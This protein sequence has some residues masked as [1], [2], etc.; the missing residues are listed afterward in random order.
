M[1]R[2]V[3]YSVSHPLVGNLLMVLLLVLGTLAGKTLNRETFPTMALDVVRVQVVW[4]GASPREVELGICVKVEEAVRGIAGI[5]QVQSIAAENGGNITILLQRGTSPEKA[6]RD[7]QGEVDRILS[8]PEAA[9]EP[10]ISLLVQ[11][12]PVLEVVL[13]GDAERSALKEI[14]EELRDRLMKA[15]AVSQVELHGLR[16]QEISVELSE[17]AMQRHG[18]TFAQVSAAIAAANLDLTS[19]TVRGVSE[20]IRVRTFGKRYHARDLTSLVVYADPQGR[21]ILLG[22]IASVIERWEELPDDLLFNGKP[23]VALRVQ[24]S[25][26]EDTLLIVAAAKAFREQERKKLPAGLD[27]ELYA[28]MSKV[29]RDR[30][31][32]LMRNGAIGLALVLLTLTI[33]LNLRL[34][35]WV[36]V[37]LPISFAGTFLVIA[38]FGS[39][40]INVISLFGLIIVAGILV[41]DAIVVSENVYAHVERGSPPHQAAIEGTAEVAPAVI[42]SVTTTMVTFTPLFFTGGMIGKFIWQVAAIVIIALAMSLVEC[43]FV[44]P[45]H[46]A[47]SIARGQA[48]RSRKLPP[49]LRTL[50][51]VGRAVRTRFDAG[52]AWFVRRVYGPA[53]ALAVK[54]RWTS[55][56]TMIGVV[57][58]CISMLQGGQQKFVFFPRIDSDDVSARYVLAPGTPTEAATAFVRDVEDKLAILAAQLKEEDPQNRDVVLRVRTSVGRHSIRQALIAMMEGSEVVEVAA[59]ILP[60]E[61]RT[62]S[63]RDVANRLAELVGPIPGAQQIYYGNRMESTFGKP[64]HVSFLGQDRIHLRAVVDRVKTALAE[65]PGVYG[66]AD[67]A[68]RGR[69]EVHLTLTEKGRGL[70]LTLGEIALQLRQGFYGHEVHRLQRGRNEVKLMVRYPNSDRE[71]LAALEQAR[72][73]TRDGRE[74]PLPEVASWELTDGTVWLK[75]QDFEGVI[76]VFADVDESRTNAAEVIRDMNATVFADVLRDYPDVEMSMEGQSREQRKVFAGVATV[77]P[78]AL[79]IMVVILILVFQSVL[80]ALLIFLMIPL[81]FV[82][83]LLSHHAWGIPITVMSIMGFI[84]LCG[85]VINDSVVF[86]HRINTNVRNG[87]K[88]YAAA[89]QGGQD[90]FRAILLTTLTTTA[91]LG[92]LVFETS[93]QAQF[94]IPMALTLAGGLLVGTLFTLLVLPAAYLCLNDVRRV[95]RWL[96][97]GDWPDRRSVEPVAAPPHE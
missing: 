30:M 18:V 37:G 95:A 40:T 86:V 74:L 3:A 34:S 38:G 55:L 84:A 56:L 87:M 11:K 45:A 26:A 27:I 2:L 32:L 4:P 42:A 62:L 79:F 36:A 6:L 20:E 25:P 81:G 1:R 10:S 59:E 88:P 14:A 33:F 63:S 57:V 91:G 73:R 43:L 23:A 53:V 67:D 65:Y 8:F 78:M 35:F 21:S 92:P 13:F 54:R 12:T 97:T 9:E 31:D 60:G 24:K 76:Q 61:E 64:I 80:Q 96:R 5:D 75:R 41:D 82:G 69:R 83:M 52:F 94:L 50:A 49:G 46:L 77:V 68:P 19:G 90:R 22:D 72:V 66:I 15:E 71:G 89:V 93:L 16:A 48:G 44:L 70:G 28:D 85:V 29:L 51:R 17:Q 39:I 58:I 47:H 7:V